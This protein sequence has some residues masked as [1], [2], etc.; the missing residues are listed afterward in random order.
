MAQKIT[1]Q[2]KNEPKYALVTGASSGIGRE[3]SRL[4]LREGYNLIGVSRNCDNLH[5][6]EKFFPSQKII[7]FNYDLSDLANIDLLKKEIKDYNIVLVINNA[8]WGYFGDFLDKDFEEDLNMINLNVLA[9][10]KFTKIFL[11]R[12]RAND[13]GRIINISSIAG[14]SVGPLSA[15]YFA[16]KSFVTKFSVA[17]NTELKRRHSNVRVVTISPGRLQTNFAKR[18]IKNW[19]SFFARSEKAAKILPLDY[20]CRKTLKKALKRRTNRNV[21][22]LGFKNKFYCWRAKFCS[23]K[24]SAKRNYKRFLLFV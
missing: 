1:N 8:G 21:I 7:T 5:D 11:K 19:E 16:S 23:M 6:F 10:I 20:F 2:R 9:L 14:D 15:T 17:I 3:Y 4:L 12:F 24:A 13:V 22:V 18:A